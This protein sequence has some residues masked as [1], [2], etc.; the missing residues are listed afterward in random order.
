MDRKF[1]PR[2]LDFSGRFDLE[3]AHRANSVVVVTLYGISGFEF[4]APW[5]KFVPDSGGENGRK[6]KMVWAWASLG[7]EGLLR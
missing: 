1:L 4:G 3:E 7:I 2:K 5:A 6:R